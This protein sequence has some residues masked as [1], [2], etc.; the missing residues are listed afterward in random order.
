VA[1]FNQRGR[2][3]VAAGQTQA[4]RQTGLTLKGIGPEAADEASSP[5]RKR[6]LWLNGATTHKWGISVVC[7]VAMAGCARKAPDAAVPAPLPRYDYW[8]NSARE[9]A[10][11]AAAAGLMP[12]LRAAFVAEGVPPEL[13]WMAEV[14][15]GLDPDAG[16]PSGTRGLFQLTRDSARQLGLSTFLPD[17]RRDP[18]KSAR[19]VARRLRGLEEKFGSWPLALAAYN[20]GEG[21]VDR[22]VADAGTH[23][24]GIVAG[25]LPPATRRYVPEVLALVEVRTGVAPGNLPEP[26]PVK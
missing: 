16:G 20:A 24:F 14:E 19:A 15:S 1:P 11:P 8:L 17:D 2:L 13:I 4:S 5:P 18:D 12:R 21:R 25:H 10:L 26:S 23:Y 22:A 9:R 3:R 7:L 6:P